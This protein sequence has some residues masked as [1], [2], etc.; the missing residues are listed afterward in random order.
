MWAAA[1]VPGRREPLQPGR[2]AG[3]PQGHH[4]EPETPRLLPPQMKCF[5]FL[6]TAQSQHRTA[7]LRL[8]RGH[9]EGWGVI[10][11]DDVLPQPWPAPRTPALG[12]W[13]LSP[14]SA[15]PCHRLSGCGPL[16]QP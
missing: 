5:L 10:G 8:A 3:A 16:F 13:Q 6:P 2:R 9:S 15:C 11:H 12:L 14:S 1:R 7:A 4:G